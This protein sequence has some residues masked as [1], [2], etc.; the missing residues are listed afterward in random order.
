MTTPPGRPP[1]GRDSAEP[2]VLP[3]RYMC[4]LAI[5]ARRFGSSLRQRAAMTRR[6][7]RWRPRPCACL[8]ARP[9]LVFAVFQF[10]QGV[11][12]CRIDRV[13]VIAAY[14]GGELRS[15]DLG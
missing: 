1:P 10:L 4:Y 3:A 12:E 6:R 14:L 15:A 5:T 2:I 11:A 9:Y 7:Q 8:A 13:T